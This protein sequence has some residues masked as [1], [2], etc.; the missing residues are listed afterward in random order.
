MSAPDDMTGR[1][2]ISPYVKQA[3]RFCRLP[4]TVEYSRPSSQFIRPFDRWRVAFN[5]SFHSHS[6]PDHAAHAYN[7]EI[8]NA[9]RRL[10]NE[11]K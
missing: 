9:R 5:K 4:V 11:V 7:V 2:D 1:D 3:V 8:A 6:H 10:L